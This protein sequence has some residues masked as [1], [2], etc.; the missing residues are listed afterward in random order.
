MVAEHFRLK[1]EELTGRTRTKEIAIARQVAMYL[2]REENDMSLPMI[3]DLLGGRDH[4][5]VRYGVDKVAVEIEVNDGLRRDIM[6]LRER[7]Y[8][9]PGSS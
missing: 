3:G 2:L 4:S 1:V 5:T 9:A 6:L 7:V 8:A